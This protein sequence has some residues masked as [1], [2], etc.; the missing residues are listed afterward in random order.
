MTR[1][2]RGIDR[3][4]LISFGLI[5]VLLVV[6][7]FVTTSFPD[8]LTRQLQSASYLGVVALGQM[9]VIL[10]GRIDLS[11]PWAITT[12]AMVATGVGGTPGYE[13]AAIPAGLFAGLLVGLFNGIGIAV[14]RVPSMIFTLGV[15]SVLFGLMTLYT[16]GGFAPPDN[17][18]PVMVE[19][20][21]GRLIPGIPNPLLIWIALSLAFAFMLRRTVLG[22][23][24]YAI[25]NSEA[26]A[27]LSGIPERRVIIAA[28][29]VSGLCTGLA[30]VLLAGY[31]GKAAQ[32][33][34]DPYLLP[35][36]AAV[37]LGGTNVM[38]GRGTALGTVAGVLLITLLN[39]MLVVVQIPEGGRQVVYFFVVIG[40]LLLYGRGRKLRA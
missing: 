28:F 38:G 15:N 34:G 18:L 3:P 24:I 9:A 14:L 32:G 4:V 30:G 35:S 8:F 5:L 16:G 6:G 13:A 2:L 27:Y 17:A 19:I 25:G 23:S 21:G 10:L 7:A 36:I 40:M 37:V 1:T 26:A 22:R 39:S 33:M 31:A 12:A 20:A 11:I 29:L